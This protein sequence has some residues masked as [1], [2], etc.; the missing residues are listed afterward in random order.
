MSKITQL[1]D[2]TY[3]IPPEYAASNVVIIMPKI[4]RQWY[5]KWLPEGWVW[6]Q[7]KPK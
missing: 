1:T 5:L 3:A 7:V 6:H 4:S 2:K